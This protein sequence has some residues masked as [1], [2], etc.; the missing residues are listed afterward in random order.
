MT[1]TSLRLPEDFG[2]VKKA[3]CT[4]ETAVG[5][6]TYCWCQSATV[7]PRKLSHNAKEAPYYTRTGTSPHRHACLYLQQ[8]KK[9]W[10]SA[11]QIEGNLL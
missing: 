5:E 6:V 7:N 8:L 2:R 3:W 10:S 11:L 1:R 4:L 9:F